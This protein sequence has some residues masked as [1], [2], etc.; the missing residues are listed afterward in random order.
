MSGIL[1]VAALAAM[2]IGVVA[3]AAVLWL[4]MRRDGRRRRLV[5]NV[6]SILREEDPRRGEEQFKRVA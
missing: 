3:I 5:Q 6:A 2:S 4:E 1:H